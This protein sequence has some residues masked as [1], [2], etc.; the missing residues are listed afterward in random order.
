MSGRRAGRRSGHS[1]STEWQHRLRSLTSSLAF[2]PTVFAVLAV[3][4]AALLLW[5]EPDS[6]PLAALFPG[7]DDSARS[8]LATIA[9]STITLAG[10]VF[11]ITMLV[12]QLSSSQYSPTVLRTFLSDRWSHFTLA[13]FVATFTFAVV[14][15]RGVGSEGRTRPTLSVTVAQ[16][17]MLATIGVLVG[18]INHIT[19]RIRVTSILA[20]TVRELEAVVRQ[21]AGQGE[22]DR[23]EPP[24]GPG[25]VVALDEWGFV[26]FVDLPGLV[27]AA[28]DA[29]GR[30]ALVA[31]PGEFVRTG[32]P[33]MRVWGIGEDRD[34]HLRGFVECS[35]ERQ[36]DQDPAYGIRRLVDVALRALS[37]SLNDP[38]TAASAVESLREVLLMMARTGLPGP[39]HRDEDGEPRLVLPEERLE[40]HVV[41]ATREI[42]R[43]A[44]GY[45]QVE[46]ALARLDTDLALHAGVTTGAGRGCTA[47]SGSCR[48]HPAAAPRN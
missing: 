1:G 38:T 36:L 32:E 40:D 42:R 34:G 9:G 31:G 17:L 11:S 26:S 27:E 10:L 20:S 44:E 30:I 4:A 16:L 29:G 2:L 18:Y 23:G 8:I 48:S 13:T 22:P 21:R 43:H 39:L 33:V 12:L 6:G 5:I 19:R 41:L 3:A 14:V 45:P 28:R 25:R 37:P 46:E 7:D 24:P 47:R 35:D 15:L